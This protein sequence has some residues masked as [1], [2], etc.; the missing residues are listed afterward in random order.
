LISYISQ[1]G[2]STTTDPGAFMMTLVPQF[3]LDEISDC[4]FVFLV[5]ESGSMSGYKIESVKNA[6]QLFLRSLPCNCH[7]NIISFGSN[8]V[9]LWPNSVPYTDGNIE[10]ASQAVFEMRVTYHVD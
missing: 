8:Y 9:P 4:E 1:E 2:A 7:F 3:T 6:L 10:K 5:D